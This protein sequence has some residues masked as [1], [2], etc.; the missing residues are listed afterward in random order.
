MDAE[1]H[2]Y[3]DELSFRFRR[4]SLAWRL[5]LT[6]AVSSVCLG[7]ALLPDAQRPQLAI[8]G[9]ILA[10]ILGL[11]ALQF[12]LGISSG[13]PAVLLTPEGI[14]NHSL[15]G[16]TQ[17][18]WQ[19]IAAIFPYAESR[20]QYV[21]IFPRDLDSFIVRQSLWC[22]F[23]L[24]FYNYLAVAPFTIWTSALSV[25]PD[26]FWRQLMRYG[27]AYAPRLFAL[28]ESSEPEEGPHSDSPD[29]RTAAQ[30]EHAPPEHVVHDGAGR[31]R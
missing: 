1:A 4:R 20:Q 29:G 6:L 16:G 5:L 25:T 14:V 23:W 24:R 10:G 27:S 13:R 3:P 17:I 28:E 8:L 15:F 9:P 30:R 12:L 26:E 22:R 31:R 21:G 2:S 19:D 11:F 18:A 7:L